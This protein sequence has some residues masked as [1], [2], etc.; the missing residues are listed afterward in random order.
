MLFL[1][2]M[3]PCFSAS[4]NRILYKN[5]IFSSQG[6]VIRVETLKNMFFYSNPFFK[7]LRVIQPFSKFGVNF[8]TQ[9]LSL[10]Q[11]LH[12]L[13]SKR[14]KQIKSTQPDKCRRKPCVFVLGWAC[15]W[16]LV[17]SLLFSLH[18]LSFA[19]PVPRKS[20]SGVARI[21]A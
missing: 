19:R 13:G 7:V 6:T 20:F 12:S 21:L 1:P 3:K 8:I 2:K 9:G 18:D 15:G 11:M 4:D 5:L 17:I 16:M 14:S 10:S